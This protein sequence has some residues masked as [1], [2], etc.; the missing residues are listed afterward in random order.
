MT[1]GPITKTIYT[2]GKR[3]GPHFRATFFRDGM[4]Y[5]WIVYADSLLDATRMLA[6]SIEVQAE[7]DALESVTTEHGY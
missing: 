4:R 1:H 3:D 2:N 6:D 5:A 7:V